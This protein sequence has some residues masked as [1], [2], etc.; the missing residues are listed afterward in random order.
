MG[1]PGRGGQDMCRDAKTGMVTRTWPPGHGGQDT[2]TRTG[3]P[4]YG[5]QELAARTW[6]PGCGHQEQTLSL[7]FFIQVKK[8][9][10]LQ[11]FVSG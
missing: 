8:A 6:P 4:G 11:E 2:A 10:I 5:C 3:I 7:I 1:I 9:A